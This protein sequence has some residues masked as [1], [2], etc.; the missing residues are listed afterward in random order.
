MGKSVPKGIK[1]KANVIMK[2]IPDSFSASFEG[3]KSSI[4]GLKLPFSKWTTNVMAGFVTRR[5]KRT[6]AAEKKLLEEKEKKEAVMK[7]APDMVAEK[8][9]RTRKTK[10]KEEVEG[11]PI[12]EIIDEKKDEIN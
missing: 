1:S 2:E 5:K 12:E 8:K 9:P 10:K 6:I 7:E 4:R 11:I 3:N